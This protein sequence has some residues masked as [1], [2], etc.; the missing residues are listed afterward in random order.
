[1]SHVRF[2]PESGHRG[3]PLRKSALCQKRTYAPQKKENRDRRAGGLIRNRG[4]PTVDQADRR[5]GTSIDTRSL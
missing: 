4:A 1:M 5:Q 2:T 3:G